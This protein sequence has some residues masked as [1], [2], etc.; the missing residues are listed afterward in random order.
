MVFKDEE[1]E[2]IRPF[3]FYFVTKT[4]GKSSV[5]RI[6][7]E[8]KTEMELEEDDLFEREKL[9][10]PESSPLE[11]TVRSEEAEWIMRAHFK[12]GLKPETLYLAIN[13][14]DRYCSLREKRDEEEYIRLVSM[15]SL[16]IAS[17]YEDRFPPTSAE[18]DDLGDERVSPQQIISYERKILFTIEFSL[19][20]PTPPI[21]LHRLLPERWS[22]LNPRPCPFVIDNLVVY[23][24]E[25]TILD[26]RFQV[27]LP[28][29]IA[30]SSYLLALT[31]LKRVETFPT[32]E[33]ERLRL[34]HSPEDLKACQDDLK[35]FIRENKNY[36]YLCKKHG[37]ASA[38][39]DHYLKVEFIN[40]TL[41]PLSV[42]LE[43]SE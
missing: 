6:F 36:R 39:V 2:V 37:K 3:P 25:I 30:L 34:L 43:D 41:P 24:M 29:L 19:M 33:S 10:L 18:L 35:E 21:F 42:L 15:A 14:F 31:I 23:L 38:I 40:E 11:R 20:A 27:Y 9:Y 16:M 13:V 26:G 5:I 12:F 32:K 22:S 4:K 8:D 28:S 1:K 7:Q 17:K